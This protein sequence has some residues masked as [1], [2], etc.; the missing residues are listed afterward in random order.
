M[1]RRVLIALSALS[2]LLCLAL[3][4]FWV[5]SYHKA[6]RLHGRLWGKHSF[7]IASK[8]GRLTIVGFRW[9]G[10]SLWRWGVLSYPTED[11]MSFPVGNMQQYDRVLGFGVIRRPIYH[12]MP[13][14][15]ETA[16]GT[17]LVFGAA[18]AALRGSAGIVPYWC[19]VLVFAL[20]SALLAA[21]WPLRYS[22]RSLMLVVTLVAVVLG[23][24][25]TFFAR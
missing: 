15:Q 2:L 8:Q 6:D 24:I 1:I 25:M 18:T 12:V 22:L 5:R 7:I 21:R 20:Q 16:R 9:H 17:M 14:V 11:A 13:P 19:L 23:L 10:A 3:V 4:A